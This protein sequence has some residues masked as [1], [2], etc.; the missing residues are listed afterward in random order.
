MRAR[1]LDRERLEIRQEISRAGDVRLRLRVHA[2][3]DRI[4]R[5][6]EQQALAV[7]H[8]LD[9]GIVVRRIQIVQRARAAA[10]ADAVMSSSI[11]TFSAGQ[12]SGRSL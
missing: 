1:L 4:V 10:P 5:P 2:A 7:R 11:C 6:L 9:A 12:K 8:Q 3:M